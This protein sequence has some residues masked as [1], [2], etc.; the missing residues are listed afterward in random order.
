VATVPLVDPAKVPEAIRRAREAITG[1][2]FARPDL[3]HHLPGDAE[4]RGRAWPSPRTWEMAL[5]L[6]A[7]SYATAASQKAVAAAL[8]GAVGEGAGIELVS[9]LGQLDLPDPERALADPDSVTLP[10][11]G[12]RL[13]SFLTAVVAAVRADCTRQRWMACWAVIAKAAAAGVPDVA[14]RPAFDL[15]AMRDTD[16]PVPSGV[17]AFLDM[18]QQLSGAPPSPDVWASGRGGRR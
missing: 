12:D 4:G 3:T 7:T 6:L 11:R 16:W 17:D 1:F 10:E 9:Y 14:A 8:T 5:R 15:A 18:L 13:L 2:L